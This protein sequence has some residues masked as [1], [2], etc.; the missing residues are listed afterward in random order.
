MQKS[1]LI[2]WLILAV[3]LVADVMDMLD[4]TITN[5]AAPVISQSLKGGQTLMQWLGT[6]YVLAMGVFLVV[7]GRLG[8]KYGQRRIFLIGLAGFTLSSLACGL[9]FCARPNGSESPACAKPLGRCTQAGDSAVRE[10]EYR[11]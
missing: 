3:V 5:I 11:K 2:L 6:S 1:K 8:D 7:G 9:A 4:S 10:S